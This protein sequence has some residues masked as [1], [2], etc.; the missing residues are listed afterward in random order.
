MIIHSAAVPMLLPCAAGYCAL[1]FWADKMQ[2]L[3][4]FSR[5]I[6]FT[7]PRNPRHFQH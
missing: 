7:S 1:A 6:A 3:R 4:L 5:P 2:A